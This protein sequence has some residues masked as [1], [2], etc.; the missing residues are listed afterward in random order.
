M[1]AKAK[2]TAPVMFLMSD[3]IFHRKIKKNKKKL[4]SKY[5]QRLRLKFGPD[6]L[7]L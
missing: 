4:V 7:L 2:L 5:F 1:T 6:L 3:T